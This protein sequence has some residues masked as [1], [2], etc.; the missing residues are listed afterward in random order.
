MKKLFFIIFVFILSF[1]AFAQDTFDRQAIQKT[2][3]EQK[4]KIDDLEIKLNQTDLQQKDFLTIRHSLR[5]SRQDVHDLS[6]KI[7]PVLDRIQANILDIGPIP[8]GENPEP[9][10]ENIQIQRADLN[11]QSLA[12]SGLLRETEALNSKTARLL[13]K[14]AFLRRSQFIDRLFETQT[15]PFDLSLWN[16]VI[17][18]YVSQIKFIIDFVNQNILPA[19]LSITLALMLLTIAVVLSMFLSGRSMKIAL[20]HKNSDRLAIVA[21][22]LVMPA[23]AVLLGML[24]VLQ[25][26]IVQEIVNEES[27]PF[28]KQVLGICVFVILAVICTMRLNKVDLIRHRVYLL[29][30]ITAIMYAADIILLEIARTIGAP[31]EFTVAQSYIVTSAFAILLGIFSFSILKKPKGDIRYILPKQLF[32]FL[33]GLSVMMLVVNSFGYA[34]LAR[35]IFGR[36]ILLF[37]LLVIIALLR[38]SVRPHLQKIDTYFK[39]DQKQENYVFFWLSLTFDIILFFAALPLVAAIFGADWVEI[40]DWA[41]KAFLGVKIGNVSISVANISIA[42]VSFLTLLFITRSIQNVLSTKILPKTKMDPSIRQSVTQ[43]L[44]YVGLIVALLVSISA[45]GFDLTN[46]ALIAGALS[47]GIGFGL[48]SIVSNFVSGLILLFE[49]PIKVGDWIITNSGEGIV[50]KI[51]VRATE[52]ETFDRTSIIVPN[53]ELISSSVIN[54]THK[55]KIGRVI[56]TIGVSYDSDP[57]MVK[58]LLLNCAEANPMVLNTPEPNV[59][60]KDF[61]DNALI[62][63]LRFF[64]RNIGDVYKVATQ[65]RLDIWDSFKKSDIEISFPQRDLHIRSAPGLEGLFG[66]STNKTEAKENE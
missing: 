56:I 40:K 3:A 38:G 64:I 36:I 60:F 1:P 61:G 45:I 18:I 43:V 52:I 47:V 28:A 51:S 26:L 13:E 32:Y 48:Q 35:Y 16:G 4:R 65:M 12:I 46:L 7:Q 11:E 15:S 58:Q 63:D 20:K 50:K 34:A 62:F 23:G 17:Q 10:P 19:K 2:L 29:C 33:F 54:W 25:T 57:H 22:S 27:W 39:K 30:V 44:G 14:V 9:E 66:K 8:E 53:A 55:D 31:L 37:S 41:I 6:D 49:R 24:I 5:E 21:R 59:L 42:A